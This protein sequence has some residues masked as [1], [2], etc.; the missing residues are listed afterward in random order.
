MW[1]SSLPMPPQVQ[2]TPAPAGWAAAIIEVESSAPARRAG[3][4]IFMASRKPEGHSRLDDTLR[5]EVVQR[6]ERLERHVEA[7]RDA[8]QRVAGLHHV[9]LRPGGWRRSLR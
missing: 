8:V 1:R 6:A 5:M 2:R 7:L 4:S 9:G 3:N